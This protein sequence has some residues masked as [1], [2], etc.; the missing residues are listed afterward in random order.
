MTW[1]YDLT[2]TELDER[3]VAQGYPKFR[4]TQVQDWLKKG[5]HVPEDMRNLPKNLKQDL[6]E[7]FDAEH[8][9]IEQVQTSAVDGSLKYLIR[10]GEDFVEAVIMRYDYGNTLCLSSQIGCRMGCT[11]CASTGAGFVR[12][13]TAGEM[14]A[15]YAILARDAALNLERVVIM[16]IGE[17]LENLDEVL[18]FVRRL[19]AEYDISKRRI[20]IST[21]GLVPQMNELAQA[22]EPITL[23]ISLHS[24]IQTKREEIMPIAKRYPLDELLAAS[25]SYFVTTGRRI[26]YEYLMIR[27][28]NDGEEDLAALL[29][30]LRKAPGHVNLIP[31]N[32]YPGMVLRPSTDDRLMY[33]LNTLKQEGIPVS[34][35]RSLGSDIDAACGQLRRQ[36]GEDMPR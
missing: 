5:V 30:A 3:I 26:S 9:R 15:T 12:N 13:L 7:W 11:F 22:N 28:F 17:P 21:C 32:D 23:A 16:G 29:R 8:L 24:A 35:R 14:L 10:C 25:R 4:A 2:P 6:V 20:T 34:R 19:N 1:I 36:K 18:S 33:F 27:D 31:L